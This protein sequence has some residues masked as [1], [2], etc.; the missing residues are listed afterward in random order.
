[1][2]QRCSLRSQCLHKNYIE[3]ALLASLADKHLWKLH[4]IPSGRV[5]LKFEKSIPQSGFVPVMATSST[6]PEDTFRATLFGGHLGPSIL[7]KIWYVVPWYACIDVS[8]YELSNIDWELA[9]VYCKFIFGHRRHPDNT[10]HNARYRTFV[11]SM[12]LTFLNHRQNFNN[13]VLTLDR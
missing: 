10:S 3:K 12:Q 13:L 6:Y 11:N 4:L 9:E 8:E 5:V 1:M 7:L 2:V